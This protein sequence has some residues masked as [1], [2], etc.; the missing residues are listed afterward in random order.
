MENLSAALLIL[1]AIA[2]TACGGKE[3]NPQSALAAGPERTIVINQ[4]SFGMPF[5]YTPISK[6]SLPLQKWSEAV[7]YVDYAEGGSATGFFISPDGLFLTNEHVISRERCSIE[8]CA[9]VRITRQ[10]APNGAFETFQD[11]QVLAHH[12]R[13]DFALVQV[14]LPPGKTVPFLK[15]SS[16]DWDQANPSRYSAILDTTYQILGHPMGGSLQVSAAKVYHYDRDLIT[17]T[18][19]ALSGTSGSPLLDTESGEVVGLYHAGYWPKS[20]V[21]REGSIQHFG[22]A[23]RITS[24]KKWIDA[25]KNKE[26]L[27]A[28]IAPQSQETLIKSHLT[29]AAWIGQI[30]GKNTTFLQDRWT[31]VLLEEQKDRL[32]RDLRLVEFANT[33]LDLLSISPQ[34]SPVDP[35]FK[36]SLEDALIAQEDLQTLRRLRYLSGQITQVECLDEVQKSIKS[37]YVPLLSTINCESRM[38]GTTPANQRSILN[39]ILQEAP[40]RRAFSILQAQIGLEPSQTPVN[41]AVISWVTRY[42]DQSTT[43]SSAYG[44]EGWLTLY[45]H[46][47]DLVRAKVGFAQAF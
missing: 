3:S 34:S 17:L 21:T 24:V 8:R 41:P 4:N 2:L 23:I 35:E 11:F 5:V 22:E 47:P 37:I 30:A 19:V 29:N 9:G 38:I 7:A 10:M 44:A 28:D 39:L 18:S 45:Q 46:N 20:T 1:S 16:E 12:S 36:K 15:L 33:Y 43:V 27:P 6:A 32:D 25:V 26:K 40:S 31:R 14:K 42:I 13:L